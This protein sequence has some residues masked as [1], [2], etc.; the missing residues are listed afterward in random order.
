MI[1]RQTEAFQDDINSISPSDFK[2]AMN[3]T[4]TIY[5]YLEKIESTK[6]LLNIPFSDYYVYLIKGET[7]DQYG[8][9]FDTYRI[10]FDG[11][12]LLILITLKG[13]PKQCILSNFE[14]S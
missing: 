10:S 2:R 11:F 3:F 14:V 12:N 7:V 6:E 13:N 1:V 9:D 5:K 4:G 8:P